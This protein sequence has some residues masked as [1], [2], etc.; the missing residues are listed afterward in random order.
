MGFFTE[1]Q[2]RSK[3]VLEHV[4][5]E[6]AEKRKD[7]RR[8]CQRDAFR[9]HFQEN[10]S[11]HEAGTQRDEVSQELM[12]PFAVRDD[13]S[14]DHIGESRGDSKKKRLCKMGS[15]AVPDGHNVAV[16]DGIFFSFQSEKAFFLE[17]LHR[18]V[19]HEVVV[20]AHFRP[21][22]VIGKVGVNH[23]GGILCISVR[24]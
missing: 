4:H 2:M 23:A 15:S 19:F 6:I 8:L 21:D 3:G 18:T 1:M 16:F 24:V 11:Q 22:E 5:D 9:K 7:W 12:G 10:G 13:D 20:V 14:A 17:G